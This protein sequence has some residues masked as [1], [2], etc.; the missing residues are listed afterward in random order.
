MQKLKTDAGITL[1]LTNMDDPD[2][3]G[4][5]VQYRCGWY[6]GGGMDSLT[7]FFM[8]VDEY[9]A[10]KAKQFARATNFEAHIY[11][12][13]GIDLKEIVDKMDYEP[14]TLHD[15]SKDLPLKVFQCHPPMS[16]RIIQLCFEP[17]GEDTVN[18][19]IN[20]NTWLYS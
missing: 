11:P 10:F 16:K 17:A 1:T 13:E 19:V 8:L 3:V 18:L 5:F 7:N 2:G 14:L 4:T 12:F 9:L 6:V 15:G 20:G